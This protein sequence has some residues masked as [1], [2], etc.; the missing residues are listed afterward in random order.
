MIPISYGCFSHVSPVDLPVDLNLIMPEEPV[1]VE[2]LSVIY[3]CRATGCER[4]T[5]ESVRCIS[6]LR[7]GT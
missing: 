4:S 5:A 2:R 7:K 6:S 1:A 3:C